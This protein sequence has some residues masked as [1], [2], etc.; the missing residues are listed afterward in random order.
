MK[1]IFSLTTI[2]SIIAIVFS[3]FIQNVKASTSPLQISPFH[4]NGNSP[5]GVFYAPTPY[6]F[7][8]NGGTVWLSNLSNGTGNIYTDDKIDIEVTQPDGAK[9]IFSH[10][11]GNGETI[12]PTAPQDVTNLFKTGTN[13]VKVTMTDLHAPYCNSSE[14]WLV[15]TTNGGGT[16]P[17]KPNI[18]PRSAWKGDNSGAINSQTANHIVI[19]H[20]ATSNIPF[21]TGTLLRELWESIRL[22]PVKAVIGTLDLTD[23]LNAKGD[24]ASIRGTWAGEIFLAWIDHKFIRQNYNDI[25]YHYLVDPNGTIYEG[26]W[27]GSLGENA[28]NLGA[29]VSEANTGVV[30]IAVLGKYGSDGKSAFMDTQDGGIAKPTNASINSLKSLVD[31]LAGK[32]GINKIGQYQI[33]QFVG[34]ERSCELSPELCYVN[35]IAGHRDFPAKT[36]TS[37]TECPGDIYNYLA[38][39][40][41]TSSAM[42]GGT[43]P[44]YTKPTG[45]LFGGFSPIVLGVVDPTGKRI[46]IDPATSQYVNNVPGGTHG[47]FGNLF[48][49]EPETA[50]SNSYAVHI[51]TTIS[52]VYKID[53]VGTG[54]GNFYLG[55]EALDT[56][57]ARVMKG[58]TDDGQKDNYQLIFSTVNPSSLELFH[59]TTLPVTTGTMTCSRD[60]NGVCRSAATVSLTATDAGTNGDQASGVAKVECSYD[61][62]ITWQQCG[63]ATGGQIVFNKNGKTS[64]YYRSTDRVENVEASKYSGIIDVE[65]FLSI[66]DTAFNTNYATGLQTSGILHSN[67]SMSF[68]YNTTVALDILTYVGTFTQSGNTTFTYNSKTKVTQ[69]NPIPSYSLSYY[70]SKCPNYKGPLTIKDTSPVYNKCMYVTGDVTLK[71]TSPTGKLT[72]ISEG[73]IKDYNNGASLQAWD[74]TNGILFYSAKGYSAST[75]QSTYTGVIYTPTSKIDGGFSNTTLY[76]GLYSKTVGFSSST[77][78]KAYQ[79]AGFL[80]T[81]YNL[82]L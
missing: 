44:T 21:G 35:N 45:L 5:C 17:A 80:E 13:S 64:F 62:K 72:I 59:D 60:M 61:N 63:D 23:A 42:P 52:G 76:G 74:T 16:L 15:E 19:H 78:L 79:A 32:Y 70:K 11:Y 29:A 22:D 73:Y 69:K 36:K 24:Y 82:P 48:D 57:K 55:T 58:T 8:Y 47:A 37:S 18:L 54:T 49:P 1:K 71:A 56:A 40:R 10:D 34:V 51:P 12:I 43:M 14:Y 81:T 9:T 30:S 25:G 65:Q 3:A 20:T 28:D 39:L 53:V 4:G 68:K 6:S 2:I 46:G 31:W 67:G 38:T 50:T 27:K 77:S 41:G 66:A 33:Q 75:N 7:S 26:R